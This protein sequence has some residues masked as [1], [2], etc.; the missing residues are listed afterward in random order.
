MAKRRKR[1]IQ[2]AAKRRDKRRGKEPPK[3]KPKVEEVDPTRIR[4]KTNPDLPDLPGLNRPQ[5]KVLVDRTVKLDHDRAFRYCDLPIFEGERQIANMH[6]QTLYDRM[7]RGSF[8]PRLVVL[9]TCRFGGQTYKI[10]GQH[11]C[12]ALVNMPSHYSIDVR[13]VQFH[14]T[15]QDD[16]RSVYSM[17]D[18]NLPRSEGHLTKV[19]LVHTDVA[20]GVWTSH[21][22]RLTAG[23]KF[24][25]FDTYQKRSRYKDEEMASLAHEYKET[26]RAVAFTIQENHD[27]AGLIKRQPVIAAMF[28]TFDKVPTIARGFW[29][30]IV[31]GLNLTDRSDPRY[32]LRRYLQD[33]AISSPSRYSGKKAVEPEA[34]YRVCIAGWNKW[35]KGETAQVSIR[36][37]NKR[38]RVV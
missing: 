28:A 20:E 21:I 22:N 12:W 35:R 1:K 17:F 6:V 24:W 16:L 4:F 10:N 3:E 32:K 19:R 9:A 7:R 18:Q 13:E 29:Q 37:A 8:N 11:T 26:F 15:T 25:L 30:T 34:M 2:Q 14:V 38:V 27:D 31:D 23:L 33:S 5:Y 36:A